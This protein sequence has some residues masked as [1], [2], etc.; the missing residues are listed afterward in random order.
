MEAGVEASLAANLPTWVSLVTTYLGVPLGVAIILVIAF[1]AAKMMW[2]MHK[3]DDARSDGAVSSFDQLSRI[4]DNKDR[5]VERLTQ[6]ASDASDRANE[7]YRE[8]NEAVSEAAAQRVR[9]EML[10]AQ[11]QALNE[12]IRHLEDQIR[13][14]LEA[15][16][17]NGS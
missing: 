9:I 8:R 16:N 13:S 5:E 3:V 2:N 12:R 15:M 4:L 1:L 6:L 14:L 7:A 10:T 17:V 11:V